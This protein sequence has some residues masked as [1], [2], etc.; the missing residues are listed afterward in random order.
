MK[1]HCVPRA[2]L[3][4]LLFLVAACAAPVTEIDSDA[5]P[6][7]WMASPPVDAHYFY[8]VGQCGP[9][10]HPQDSKDKALARAVTELATQGGVEI[11]SESLLFQRM[12][13]NYQIQEWSQEI[14]AK[15]EGIIRNFTIRSRHT[16]SRVGGHNYAAGTHFILVRIERAKM[17]LEHR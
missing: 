12:R 4:L 13:G 9:T 7:E 1:K 3:S 15:V 2:A 17:N 11:Q 5:C 16:C 14:H 6:P 10:F 8:G